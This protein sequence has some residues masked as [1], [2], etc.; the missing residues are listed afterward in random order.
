MSFIHPFQ[1][2]RFRSTDGLTTFGPQHVWTT[3]SMQVLDD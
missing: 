3:P 1:I 2:E